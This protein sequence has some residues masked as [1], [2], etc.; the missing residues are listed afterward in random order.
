MATLISRVRAISQS[1]TSETPDTEVIE[2]LKQGANFLVNSL[3]LEKLWFASKS[4]AITTT[5]GAPV[6]TDKIISV[7]RNDLAC[8]E[9]PTDMIYTQ[10][11]TSI[12]GS[13]SMYKGSAIFPVYY[14]INK[15]TLRT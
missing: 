12:L 5:T 4:V 9:I 10:S 2:F 13:E 1:T 14:K 8:V 3:P 11:T 15:L 6:T 7:T